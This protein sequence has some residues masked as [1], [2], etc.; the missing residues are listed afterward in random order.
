MRFTT[1][2]ERRLHPQAGLIP[3]HFWGQIPFEDELSM[4]DSLIELMAAEKKNIIPLLDDEKYYDLHDSP[5]SIQRTLLAI[6]CRP[7]FDDAFDELINGLSEAWRLTPEDLQKQFHEASIRELE[8]STSTITLAAQESEPCFLTDKQKCD[9]RMMLNF[10]P[11]ESLE[12]LLHTD[13]DRGITYD[14][15]QAELRADGYR[16]FLS[17]A[18]QGDL[19]NIKF[20]MELL[21]KARQEMLVVRNHEVFLHAAIGGDLPTIKYLLEQAAG[22]QIPI[23]ALLHA[24]NNYRV[25]RAAISHGHGRVVEYLINAMA[26]KGFAQEMIEADEFRAF[27]LAIKNHIPLIKYMARFIPK[28]LIIDCLTADNYEVFYRAIHINNLEFV[29][30]SMDQLD[31]AQDIIVAN[32]YRTLSIAS[33]SYKTDLIRYFMGKLTPEARQAAI[34]ANNY[35]LVLKAMRSPTYSSAPDSSM[36]DFFLSIP[37]VFAAVCDNKANADLVNRWVNQKL[38]TIKRRM[39]DLDSHALAVADAFE[40]AVN[41][42]VITG[43]RRNFTCHLSI[44]IDPEEATLYLHIVCYLK[45][46]DAPLHEKICLLLKIPA[47]KRLYESLVPSEMPPEALAAITGE[48]TAFDG[49]TRAIAKGER[50]YTE[51]GDVITLYDAEDVLHTKIIN[52]NS[53]VRIVE[54]YDV[55]GIIAQERIETSDISSMRIDCLIYQDEQPFEAI[56][57][58]HS[59]AQTMHTTRSSLT[60]AQYLQHKS[61]LL[62]LPAIYGSE[63]PKEN[64][65]NS[66]DN[67]RQDTPSQT[68]LIEKAREVFDDLKRKKTRIVYV[69]G[70]AGC[71]ETHIAVAL[72][73][74]ILDSKQSVLFL[75]QKTLSSLNI[76]D[77]YP[78]CAAIIMD[79][80]SLLEPDKYYIAPEIP[81]N[82]RLAKR[83]S[84]AIRIRHEVERLMDWCTEATHRRQL[85]WLSAN[86]TCLA[87]LFD[88]TR[89][90]NDIQ[91]EKARGL[92]VEA[93]EALLRFAE[94]THFEPIHVQKNTVIADIINETS[95]IPEV[96]PLISPVLEDSSFVDDAPMVEEAHF[97]SDTHISRAP[98]TKSTS[99]FPIDPASLPSSR[100]NSTSAQRMRLFPTGLPSS[101][102]ISTK[103]PRMRQNVLLTVTKG[104]QDK[105]E[106]FEGYSDSQML[107]YFLNA[108]AKGSQDKVRHLLDCS[109]SPKLH[110]TPIRFVDYSGRVFNCT[111]YEYAYWAN[112][113][114][115]CR[116][117]EN[118]MDE[119]TKSE[120]STRIHA[121]EKINEDGKQGLVYFQN[122]VKHQR[123]HFE[124]DPLKTALQ[125]C[126]NIA[127]NP[128]ASA[129]EMKNAWLNLGR[130]QRDL[131]LHAVQE[132][133]G[134]EI[135]NTSGGDISWFPLTPTG[136]GF[137]YAFMREGRSLITEPPDTPELFLARAQ[138]DLLAISRMDESRAEE[139][140][141]L[142]LNLSSHLPRSVE[143]SM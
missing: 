102:I 94:E 25:F 136:L 127:R 45:R 20:L 85:L 34:A 48:L 51:Q 121:M 14:Q 23:H 58:R 38:D 41:Q 65:Y 96:P 24:G 120:L 134:E 91:K 113:T 8:I 55:D 124:W 132:Y 57:I 27:H 93:L 123:V 99:S 12:T 69:Y 141:A 78:R 53:K 140:I 82:K 108:V 135:S 98:L 5:S 35:A 67:F 6:S 84:K 46:L 122:G 29:D 81:V 21:P 43:R 37:S 114:G 143:L 50:S 19:E 15:V 44:D 86:Q 60:S 74:A 31:A 76:L 17:L 30:W 111:A 130:A 66:F 63:L 125:T 89:I 47:V 2:E 105:V 49:F 80:L 129:V 52:L 90:R 100:I 13:W 103:A 126:I 75:Q 109:N 40:H 101:P 61:S 4:S 142:D 10:T 16:V 118:Y 7:D 56:T 68:R 112:D 72:A 22:Y 97:E 117:L 115:K 139:R 32:N 33:K 119:E 59:D 133:L 42:G 77:S 26:A 116:I 106:Q 95:V 18:R 73:R 70:D 83:V 110:L 107:H 54:Q 79:G 92:N 104:A 71:G 62:K 87:A 64:R 128:T 131:P 39:D 9:L 137:D 138:Q 3:D 88:P 36:I 1:I 28:S 11:L